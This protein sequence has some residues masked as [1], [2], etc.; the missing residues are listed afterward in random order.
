MKAADLKLVVKEKYGEIATQSFTQN[1]T[2]CCGA[3]SSCCDT[4]YSIFADDYTQLPGYNADADLALGCGIPV[5]SSLL[6]SGDWVLDLG[7]GAGNDC[8]VA[9][10]FVGD[11]GKVVGLDFTPQ[12]LDK[13]RK[14][15][16]KLGFS[17]VEFVEGDIEEMPLD[18]NQFDVVVSNCVLN[19][20][21]NKQKA[22]E[23]IYRVLKSGGKFSISDVVLIGNL[24][25]KL[26]HDATMYAGCVSGAIEK[27]V[28]LD[29]VKEAGFSDIEVV[30]EKQIDIP[31]EILANYMTDS[32]I[33][34]FKGG[35]AG[36]FSITVTARK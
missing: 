19:L 14:N 1:Q 36:I 33:S 10:S 22:F 15:V 30:K 28:Y 8:F 2:S 23:Q 31:N 6:K 25:E 18:S 7:S 35:S 9:R 27:L 32:E 17:N 24:P 5:S 20:V 26:L 4:T 16:A 12:M 21:P 29:F 34:S 3:G 13:A 11:S